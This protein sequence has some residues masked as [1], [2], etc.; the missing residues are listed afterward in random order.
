MLSPEKALAQVRKEHQERIERW[1]GRVGEF[2]V[3]ELMGVDT[4]QR[5]DWNFKLAANGFI[6]TVPEELREEI[7][8]R[9]RSAGW[10]VEWVTIGTWWK[11]KRLRITLR[12]TPEEPDCD[13]PEVCLDA[14]PHRT[15]PAVCPACG[16]P[17]KK[18]ST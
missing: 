13:H 4:P 10:G 5:I 11:R 9:L 14:H 12:R 8:E 6:Y 16:Q 1:V 18:E 2:L 7:V 15:P 17:R 3:Q